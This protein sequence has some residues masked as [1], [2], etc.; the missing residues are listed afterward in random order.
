MPRAVVFPGGQVDAE[1][2]SATAEAGPPGSQA[3]RLAALQCAALRETFEEAGL[4]LAQPASA[5]SCA[6]DAFAAARGALRQGGGA[7][8][9]QA[10]LAKF[11]AGLALQALAPLVCFIT[12]DLESKRMAKSGFEAHFFVAEI[13][14]AEAATGATADGSEVTNLVWAAP[15]VALELA[16]RGELALAP[17][18][19]YILHEL[20]QRLHRLE[21]LRGFLAAPENSLM[22]DFPFKPEPLEGDAG[23]SSL[24][25]PGDDEHPQFPGPAGRRHRILVKIGGPGIFQV[26]GLERTVQYPS[27]HIGDASSA[28]SRL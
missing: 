3:A 19:W 2:Y 25:L 24:A 18:Q 16:G 26:R 11:G 21:N 9:L 27:D 17:P 4:L 20:H 14:C 13:P 12:P 1:D 22:R 23:S 28:A 8:Q 6:G 10:A 7:R 5:C 15:S